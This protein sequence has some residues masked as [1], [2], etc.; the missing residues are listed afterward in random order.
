M[1]HPPQWEVALAS[2]PEEPARL[3][4]TDRL[5]H[6]VDLQWRKLKYAPKLELLLTKHKQ[7]S[8]RDTAKVSQLKTAPAPWKGVVHKVSE[9]TIIHAVRF[10]KPVRLI[11][12]V[13]L[14]WPDR[15]DLVLEARIL[16]SICP[17]DCEA[18][19]QLWQAMGMSVTCP[20]IFDLRDADL[21]VGRIRWDFT[22]ASKRGPQ[23]S[24]QRIAMPEYVLKSGPLRDW[25]RRELPR[26]SRELRHTTVPQNQHRA[27]QFISISKGPIT[28]LLQKRRM[29][30]LD[31]AWRCEIEQRI[32]SVRY[33]EQSRDEEE[34][35]LPQGWNVR[36]CHQRPQV[37]E[38]RAVG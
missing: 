27:E 30:H 35:A 7:R 26:G 17:L 12:E 24:I 8:D 19:G 4:L 29:L 28:G 33:S 9:T 2:G 1:D 14:V 37:S 15:R 11:A 31:L 22:T 6:R 21:K 3:I 13:T 10:F 32:Y 38:S 34:I 23:L 16:G 25:A 20:P 36:C 18:G 5:H